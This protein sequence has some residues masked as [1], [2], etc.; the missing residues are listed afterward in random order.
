MHSLSVCRYY[1]DDQSGLHGSLG[2]D[3]LLLP[4]HTHIHTHILQKAA[5]GSR[6]P[7]S[8]VAKQD[9]MDMYQKRCQAA[10]VN[11]HTASSLGVLLHGIAT[12][13]AIL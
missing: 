2:I 1:A 10:G 4:F 13:E 8:G 3:P 5:V 6:Y 11:R 12:D 7:S 9:K